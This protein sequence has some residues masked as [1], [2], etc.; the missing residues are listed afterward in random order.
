MFRAP[1]LPPSCSPPRLSQAPAATLS[2]EERALLLART[3]LLQVLLPTH[4][5]ITFQNHPVGE[6]GSWKRGD[7]ARLPP[8]SPLLPKASHAPL[9]WPLDPVGAGDLHNLIR[10]PIV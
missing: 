10:H 4:F 1:S 8:S 7:L 2:V 5:A 9:A 6:P 3:H